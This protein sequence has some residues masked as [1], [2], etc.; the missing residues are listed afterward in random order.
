MS[1]GRFP[2]LCP[3]VATCALLVGSVA[4]LAAGVLWADRRKSAGEPG[5]VGQRMQAI[6]AIVTTVTCSIFAGDIP[7]TLVRIPGTPASAAYVSDA[8][9]LTR[10]GLHLRALGVSLTFS[11]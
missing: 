10:R 4:T 8:Y 2:T 7:A 5:V 1:A 9:T 3:L 6:A 11:V